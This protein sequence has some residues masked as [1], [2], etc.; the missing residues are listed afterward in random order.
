L[1]RTAID[2]SVLLINEFSLK[3]RF[4]P[5]MEQLAMYNA[6]SQSFSGQP[7]HGSSK[8]A[9]SKEIDFTADIASRGVV[10]VRPVD[11]PVAQG[12]RITIGLGQPSARGGAS[13]SV[14]GRAIELNAIS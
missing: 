13:V 10:R 1:P 6:L 11:R 8:D 4:L 12:K 5:H 3:I 14:D 9:G 7:T 2:T